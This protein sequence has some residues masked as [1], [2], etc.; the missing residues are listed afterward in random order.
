MAGMLLSGLSLRTVSR[1]HLLILIIAATLAFPGVSFS[2]PQNNLFILTGGGSLLTVNLE[3]RPDGSMEIGRTKLI[4]TITF[5]LPYSGLYDFF[6]GLIKK[7]DYFYTTYGSP[8]H[9]VRFGLNPGDEVIIGQLTTHSPQ[10]AMD[11]NGTVWIASSSAD[12]TNLATIDFPL[13][14]GPPIIP[15][16][17]F[18]SGWYPLSM[19]FDSQNQL[20]VVPSTAGTSIARF[21]NPLDGSWVESCLSPDQP[22][23]TEPCW[24]DSNATL[25]TAMATDLSTGTIYDFSCPGAEGLC[26]C[27][28]N[29]V[30]PPTS[31]GSKKIAITEILGRFKTRETC[32][33]NTE[34]S[35]FVMGA[36]FASFPPFDQSMKYSNRNLFIEDS[37]NIGRLVWW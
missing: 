17:N 12:S 4:R 5:N 26:D 36:T 9:V 20:L 1:F 24:F 11:S 14:L 30:Q 3:N 22:S 16:P 34:H 35:D 28:I 2:Q 10:L 25:V 13:T 21:N 33:P 37:P 18:S 32:L 7:G 31:F 6:Q 23:H 27:Q 29:K 19:S 8:S 15:K